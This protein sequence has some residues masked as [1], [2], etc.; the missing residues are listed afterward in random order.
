M[1]NGCVS[2]PPNPDSY[3]PL[4]NAQWIGPWRLAII[5]TGSP[6]CATTGGWTGSKSLG[7]SRTVP[8]ASTTAYGLTCTRPEYACRWARDYEYSPPPPP[9]SCQRCSNNYKYAYGEWP[10]GPDGICDT[11]DDNYGAAT[12]TCDCSCTAGSNT[13]WNP[14]CVNSCVSG[15]TYFFYPRCSSSYLTLASSTIKDTFYVT[16]DTYGPS[17]A[18]REVT[19]A[20]V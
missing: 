19:L 4:N 15:G 5:E 8:P 10:P 11:A 3:T 16:G 20:V 12:Y 7:G 14:A 2:S 17:T 13:T 1:T 18:S 6:S 9:A